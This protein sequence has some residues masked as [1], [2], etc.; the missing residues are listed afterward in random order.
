MSDC[1]HRP[2]KVVA[3]RGDWGV[4]RSTCLGCGC[5]LI[6]TWQDY[7]DPEGAAGRW[8]RWRL[9]PTPVRA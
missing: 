6:Q 7:G 1:Q 5:P 8:T 9:A 4:V 3:D 2:G